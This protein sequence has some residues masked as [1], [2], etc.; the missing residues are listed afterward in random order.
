MSWDNTDRRRFHKSL[1]HVETFLVWRLRRR[2][3]MKKLLTMM[4]LGILCLSS[5]SMLT[6]K[7]RADDQTP[8][9]YVDPASVAFWT[10]AY[11]KTFPVNVDVANVVGLYGYEFMLFWNATLLNVVGVNVTLLYSNYF[12]AENDTSVA[13]RYW[14]AISLLPNA[15]I[16]S[17][18]ATL[19]TL[20]F[21]IAYDPIYPDN[22]TS[23]LHLTD[24]LLSD[25]NAAPIGHST[26]DGQYT[27]YSTEPTI[28]VMPTLTTAVMNETFCVNVTVSNVVDLQEYEFSLSYNASLLDVLSLQVGNFLSSPG[29]YTSII[30]HVD[31]NITMDVYSTLWLQTS[32]N[33]TLAT[34][35]FTTIPF[36]WPDPAQNTT[37]HLY[38]TYLW[39]GTPTV[40]ITHNDVDAN[41]SYTPI[42]G[43]INSDG[44]VNLVDLRLV[45]RAYGTRPGD[46]Y[47][48]P[49]CDVHRDGVID[50]FD[51]VLVAK[52]QGKTA[53]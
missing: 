41:Y 21:K 44:I 16:F 46:T 7:S 33:G 26:V 30:D 5:F 4:I 3:K 14:L 9:L 17:G 51:L 1:I 42:P 49:R 12:I 10:P 11:G 36:V 50:I 25:A 47:W 45:A 34:I 13:G 27:L 23:S 6:P 35:N 22:V 39:G 20:S 15:T 38:D 18:N 31:G 40:A 2:K 53:P 8:S 29:V 48:D 19:V 28:Q 43:D 52:N 32:G 24:D 37:L